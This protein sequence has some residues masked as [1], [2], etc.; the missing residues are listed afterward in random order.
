M[1][2]VVWWYSESS[3]Y[4]GIQRCSLANNA[5]ENFR[6]CRRAAN[7][8]KVSFLA[9]IRRIIRPQIKETSDTWTPVT[10]AE[11][12]SGLWEDEDERP[13]LYIADAVRT[14]SSNWPRAI[15][16]EPNDIMRRVHRI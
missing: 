14:S 5:A 4:T 1:G 15:D 9:Y 12:M 13:L 7:S 16:V 6:K 11:G 3:P 2:T 10:G 8:T